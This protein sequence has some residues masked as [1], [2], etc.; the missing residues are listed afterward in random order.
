MSIHN[1]STLNIEHADS[2]IDEWTSR[3]HIRIGCWAVAIL[4]AGLRA[5]A[6]RNYL[7][8][9]DAIS[10]LDLAGHFARGN[11]SQAI[12]SYWSS[13]YPALLG[14]ALRVLRPSP[15]WEFPVAH[16]VN[17]LIFVAAFGAFDFL[18]QQLKNADGSDVLQPNRTSR[19]L[20]EP[21]WLGTSYLVFLYC[22]MILSG[23]QVVTPDVLMG[24]FLL[25]GAAFTVRIRGGKSAWVDYAAVGFAW[26]AGYL[27][28]AAM[29][30]LGFVFLLTVPLC[31]KRNKIRA[32]LILAATATLIVGPW[33]W[34]VSRT[35][36]PVATGSSGSLNY[37]WFVNGSWSVNGAHGARGA[38]PTG[39]VLY[40]APRRIFD[41]PAAFEFAG[42]VPGTYPPWDDPAYWNEGLLPHFSLAQELKRI[43]VSG[44]DYVRL[45]LW[46][47]GAITATILVMV[48]LVAIRFHTRVLFQQWPLLA[49]A[50]AGFAMYALI[51]V[52]ERFLGTIS[53]IFWLAIISSIALP[54]TNESRLIIRTT[55]M[56]L[57]LLLGM[58]LLADTIG[59]FTG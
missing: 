10:Y 11:L 4:L 48:I 50:V 22:E 14:V 9:N 17:F 12:N 56:A 53:V 13:L 58:Y 45:F 21:L 5:W 57:M 43:A 2:R 25:I 59:D 27:A 49:L 33:I 7:Q 20:D 41:D 29:L 39:P 3:S 8:S 44:G 26:G 36:G 28:K 31:E 35:V 30:P 23:L 1:A 42:P 32:T 47:L 52:D 38:C 51:R 19:L 55:A 37:A 18:L 46:K 54:A 16:A 24:M 34:V 6:S 40:H 15:Y